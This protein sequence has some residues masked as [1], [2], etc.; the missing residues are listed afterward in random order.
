MVASSFSAMTFCTQCTNI[1]NR[2]FLELSRDFFR[3]LRWRQ[4]SQRGE[5]GQLIVG[6]C[7]LRWAH[8]WETGRHPYQSYLT[9]NMTSRH[10]GM[11]R[12]RL[13]HPSTLLCHS[14]IYGSV[15]YVANIIFFIIECGVVQFLCAMHVFN[16][17]CMRG[18]EKKLNKEKVETGYQSR[19]I[20]W[21]KEYSTHGTACLVN[22]KTV[23]GFK[24]ETTWT[25]DVHAAV[26][27]NDA[28][29]ANDANNAHEGHWAV[30]ECV[31]FNVP[32][33]T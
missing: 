32:L 31:G 10:R 7:W 23:N 33:D 20:L 22:A 16:H 11:K 21:V 14:T 29:T 19:S 8:R 3:W 2:L 27:L 6:F 13:W 28:H 5:T 4:Q 25:S 26:M 24:N 1:S 17:Y 15:S 12:K 18:H 30:S 9:R